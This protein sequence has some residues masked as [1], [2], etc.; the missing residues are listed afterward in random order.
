MM[1][2]AKAT[3][4]DEYIEMKT[5]SEYKISWEDFD[6]N[7]YRSITTGNLIRTIVGKKWFSGNFKYSYLSEEECEQILQMINNYPIYVQI[8]DPLF[9]VNG[10]VELQAYCSKISVEMLRN[11]EDG[12]T[13]RNLSF[14]I[15]Q[16][17]KI[18]GQ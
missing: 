15:I 18:G 14:N 12:A 3:I 4:N 11:Q 10:V 2:K 6:S 16:S 7:S 5:P 9:G 1:W 13:W 8:K 17:R